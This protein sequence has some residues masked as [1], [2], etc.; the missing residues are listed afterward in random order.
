MPAFEV[1]ADRQPVE[2]GRSEVIEHS[3]IDQDGSSK[4]NEEPSCELKAFNGEKAIEREHA[5]SEGRAK[6]GRSLFP[7]R[8]LPPSGWS[9]VTAALA[10]M[11]LP[12]AGG[13]SWSWNL[14]IALTHLI[15]WQILS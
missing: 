4:S 14:G 15:H 12:H 3:L 10:P 1:F 7:G 6:M 5:D 2:W 11:P 9:F 13:N 8:A